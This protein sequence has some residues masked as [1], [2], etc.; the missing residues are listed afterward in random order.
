MQVPR[1]PRRPAGLGASL[2]LGLLLAALTGAASVA[3]A[4]FPEARYD[5]SAFVTIIDATRYDDRFETVG[6]LLRQVAGVRVRRVGGLGSASTASIRG[7]KPE[8]VLVLLDGVR[9]NSSQRGAVDLATLPVRSIAEIEVVRG[10]GSSRYGSDA[11]GGVISIRTRAP[12]SGSSLD[13]AALAGRHETLGVDALLGHDGDRGGVL[14]GYTRLRSDNDFD[15]RVPS[16]DAIE[17]PG[18][19]RAALDSPRRTRLNAGFVQD[20]GLLRLARALG[21][22]GRLDGT[23]QL[24]RK[25]AGQ[26]GTT[27]DR[28]IRGARD[29][30]L[31]C[32]RP[33][34]EYRRALLRG[35]GTRARMLGGAVALSASYRYER[36]GLHDP[37]SACG[38]VDLRVTRSD[39][40]QATDQEGALDVEYRGRPLRLG[41]LR[42]HN[43]SAGTLRLAHVR[44]DD[45]EPRRR[46]VATLFTQQEIGLLD[47]RIRLLPALGLDV[48]RTED[49]LTRAAGFD[50]L[51]ETPVDDDPAWLPR[52][53]AIVRL[54][55]GAR[56]KANYR[57]AFR[58][59][60]FTELFHPDYG[61]VRGN[62]ALEPEDGWS[63][64]V[65]VELAHG[66]PPLRLEVV[67]F[68]RDVRDRIEW[69]LAGS[70]FEPRN[71]GEARARGWELHGAATLERLD[72][73]ASYTYLDTE[74]RD[75]ALARRGAPLPRS[76]RHRLF[77]SASLDLGLGR[78]WL[79]Y[80][81]EDESTL[82]L[83]GRQRID[84]WGQLDAGVS[85]RLARL[86][87]LRWVPGGVHLSSE[88]SNLTREDRVDSL[89][90]PLPSS[91]L[92]L[93][94]LRVSPE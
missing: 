57:R 11:V 41:P 37:G 76:P 73:A 24:F 50:R 1:A 22:E 61:F 13:A 43:R 75:P 56:L 39:R 44:S 31:S 46:W 84:A 91:V 71:T 94:R 63:F 89:G 27:R 21:R 34:E 51:V 8:Q 20:S 78:A 4:E 72:L 54:A 55:P 30:T 12:G 58:R 5:P 92:W 17:R 6:E 35:S 79:E 70:T 52:I 64:D 33:E 48:A 29:E 93:L 40:S 42:L 88:W 26:P 36:F 32:T 90:L 49:G 16:L 2:R 53:G 66:S 65:G 68:R 23:L 67:H 85:V 10:G 25:D 15:Y 83:A 19:G 87:G 14:V 80:G 62:P 69:L 59:P 7:S 28:P 18:R 82:N 60:N 3:A 74:L 45:S 38:L 9:L 86:P 81:W 47:G 77:A